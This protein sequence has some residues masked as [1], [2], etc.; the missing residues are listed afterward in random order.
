MP[1]PPPVAEPEIQVQA[2]SLGGDPRNL[3]WGGGGGA[4]K[5]NKTESV[6]VRSLLQQQ[7]WVLLVSA[8]GLESSKWSGTPLT[9]CPPVTMED[10]LL[11][12]SS[13]PQ[14]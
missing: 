5:R 9:M 1:L 7:G 11:P 10:W 4:G 12:P 13:C 2:V 6:L 14:Q 3:G 8:K